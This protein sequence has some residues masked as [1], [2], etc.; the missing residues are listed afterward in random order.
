MKQMKV[1]YLAHNRGFKQQALRYLTPEKEYTVLAV[2]FYNQASEFIM[3]RIKANDD[4]VR[5]FSARLFEVT[6]SKVFS[7]WIMYQA[8]TN[9]YALLPQSWA[10][11]DFWSGY[12]DGL[13]EALEDFDQEEKRILLENR[14]DI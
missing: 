8:G 14:L 4:V 2:D 1:K 13:P 12:Y 10:R 6:C 5:P 9:F 3:Y 11:E 7:G